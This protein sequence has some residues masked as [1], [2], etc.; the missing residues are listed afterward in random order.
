IL[1]TTSSSTAPD[2]TATSASRSLIWDVW[3]PCGK[4]I[5]VVG[6]TSVP[7]RRLTTSSRSAGRQQIVAVCHSIATSIAAST[8]AR[9]SSG[10]RI[11]WSMQPISVRSSRAARSIGPRLASRGF[12]RFTVL[13]A[14]YTLGHDRWGVASARFDRN[15]ARATA[16]RLAIIWNPPGCRPGQRRTAKPGPAY[17]LSPTLRDQ[18]FGTIAR[19]NLPPP[20]IAETRERPAGTVL[21]FELSPQL[22]T[23]PSDLRARLC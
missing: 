17:R 1:T 2:S 7:R 3:A 20:A 23:V 11:E 16:P 19:E 6:P 4:P 12:T 15:H 9:V 18:G 14:L 8:S 10:R 22:T 5:T 13:P 21:P